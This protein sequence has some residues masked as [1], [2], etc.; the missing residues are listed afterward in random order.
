MEKKNK[1]DI[2]AAFERS[3]LT[4]MTEECGVPAGSHVIVAVSGGADS[5]ALLAALTAVGYDCTA[6]HCNFHLRGAESQRDMHHVEALCEALG[7]DLSIKHF[8]VAAHTAAT[9]QSVEMACRE[10]RYAWFTDMLE[11][12]RARAIAVG[13][14][15]EDQAETFVLNLSRGTGLAGLTGMRVRNGL[16]VRP[17]LGM[18]RNEI[19]EYLH[20][21]GL[22]WV[23][24]STNAQND[25]RRNSIRNRVL[26]L[27]EECLPGATDAILATMSHLQDNKLLYDYAVDALS[28]PYANPS[29]TELAL[30]RLC[31]ELPQP[32][33]R[34]LL[35]ERLKVVGFNMAQVENIMRARTGTARFDSG[36]HIAEVSRGR[37]TITGANDAVL[38]PDEVR[39][40]LRQ[41]ITAPVSIDI[42]EH[43]ISEFRPERDPQIIYLD[44]S[45]LEGGP[46]FTLRHWRRGDRL[47]PFGMKGEKL[48][49]DIFAD[50]R[51]TAAEK[52]SAW[53][54]TRNGT[55][56]WIVGLRAGA[57]YPVTPD[58]HRFLKLRLLTS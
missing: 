55:P 10:L 8:D 17:M 7:V 19:E 41:P 15:R 53:L 36:S 14:H 23:D 27:M 29:G 18:S 57:P 16:V 35:F 50:A 38:G 58:T 13:H 45:V 12:S 48:V 28:A 44:I 33:A 52:R 54:L 25:F 42:T 4:A 9:G 1:S 24:D 34:M 3:V 37:L 32:V 6:A 49:S 43:H 47:R 20:A 31:E 46:V 2:T 11:R 22:M 5:V 51:L 39:V 56:L 40:S 30:A 21:R 26:P